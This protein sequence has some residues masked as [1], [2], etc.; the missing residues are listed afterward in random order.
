MV[1]F[2][3]EVYAMR[4]PA[5]KA[6]LKGIGAMEVSKLPSLEESLSIPT[7]VSMTDCLKPLIKRL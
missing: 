6:S 5:L 4:I 2:Q 7:M 3:E 1:A